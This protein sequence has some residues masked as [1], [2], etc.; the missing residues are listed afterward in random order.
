MKMQLSQMNSPT[1]GNSFREAALCA[2]A[3]EVR[4][5][6]M[7]PPSCLFDYRISLPVN[8]IY[9][10]CLSTRKIRSRRKKKGKVEEEKKI[11]GRRVATAPRRLFWQR[12]Q[13]TMHVA[14]PQLRYNYSIQLFDTTIRYKFQGYRL[15]LLLSIHQVGWRSWHHFLYKKM[16]RK[17]EEGEERENRWKREVRTTSSSM[18]PQ[19]PRQRFQTTIRIALSS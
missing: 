11:S 18:R 16:E 1:D 13:M 12:F 19:P 5:R 3:D 17:K 6:R 9:K 14:S 15:G 7:Q 8:L 10:S 4:S 2:S